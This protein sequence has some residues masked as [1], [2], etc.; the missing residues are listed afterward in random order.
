MPELERPQPTLL[1]VP[2]NV[3][4]VCNGPSWN[5]SSL[6]NHTRIRKSS[7]MVSRCHNRRPQSREAGTVE[8]A[9]ASP[10]ADV[11]AA[12]ATAAQAPAMVAVVRA[13]V[14]AMGIATRRE[15]RRAV[16]RRQTQSRHRRCRCRRTCRRS[17]CRGHHTCSHRHTCPLSE[18]APR[19]R[20]TCSRHHMCRHTCPDRRHT[21]LL[22]LEP[23]TFSASP[24][25]RF[26]PPANR[27]SHRRRSG[28]S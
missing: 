25:L 11:A 22:E 12:Q 2:C 27:P 1:D 19:R 16:V 7:L 24:E 8:Q 10:V 14:G 23:A 9:E 18:L 17:R 3:C 26:A 4:N 15:V 6:R 21:C 5:V 20:H 28:P 13:V